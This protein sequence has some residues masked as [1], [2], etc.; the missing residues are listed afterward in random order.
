MGQ[1][2]KVDKST[3]FV[4]RNGAVSYASTNAQGLA[5]VS[6]CPMQG[7]LTALGGLRLT[8]YATGAT[9]FLQGTPACTRYKGQH[10]GGTLIYTEGWGVT[11]LVGVAYRDKVKALHAAGA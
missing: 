11:F 7:L 4:H 1:K 2:F 6:N 9:T 10:I 5:K 8:C 3:K